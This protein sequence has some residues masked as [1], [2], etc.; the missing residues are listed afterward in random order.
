MADKKLSVAEIIF[1]I[2]LLC[3]LSAVSGCASQTPREDS[4]HY[5]AQTQPQDYPCP[6]CG[7]SIPDK[8][9]SP[10]IRVENKC[11]S[12]GGIFFGK[13][14]IETE[15]ES[16]S[17]DKPHQ[18]PKVFGRGYY[19]D[20]KHGSKFDHSVKNTWKASPDGSSGSMSQTFIRTYEHTTKGE[21][22]TIIGPAGLGRYGGY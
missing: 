14:V 22:G 12:C 7:F 8:D 20:I 11:F 21:H 16:E 3:G 4:N 6:E 2:I 18:G 13:P 17:Q 19:S 5:R 15:D 9:V 1:L 10:N